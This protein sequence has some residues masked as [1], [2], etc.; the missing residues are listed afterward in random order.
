MSRTPV[1]RV[2]RPLVTDS[3]VLHTDAGEPSPGSAGMFTPI[4]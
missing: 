2:D 1:D 4:D 3:K